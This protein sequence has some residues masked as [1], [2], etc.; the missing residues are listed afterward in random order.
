MKF[1]FTGGAKIMN[2]AKLGTVLAGAIRPPKLTKPNNG[3]AYRVTS[4]TLCDKLNE[5]QFA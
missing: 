1:N 5:V 2:M 4:Y 3:G